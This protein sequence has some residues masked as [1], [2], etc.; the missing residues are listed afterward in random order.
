MNNQ[1][2]F[3]LIVLLFL[4][5]LSGYGQSVQL[6][7][8]LF[9]TGKEYDQAGK[10][11][12][13]E[14]YY[15]E[16]YNMYR[17]FQDTASWL[18]AGKEYASAMMWRSKNGQ[19]LELYKE[20][21][22]V[23]HP[24]N[25]VYNQ[26][27][28]YNSMGLASKRSGD[29]DQANRYYQKSLPLSKESGDS[30]LIGVVFSNIGGIQRAKGN[31]SKAMERFKQSLPYL[32]GITQNSYFATSL[33]NIGNI[34]E[35][36]SLYDQALDYFNR[37]L[38]IQTK[39]NNVSDLS[40]TYSSLGSVQQ[41]LGNYDQAMV[42][43]NK[44]LDFSRT[45]G[46]PSQTAQI[47]NDIG[48]LYKRLG[49]YDKALDYYRQSLAI[50]K[51]ASGPESIATTTNNIGQLMWE[52]GKKEEA[53]S[54]YRE[55]LDMRKKM[56]NPHEIYYSLNTMARMHL[57]N[58]Q[59]DE[60]E[61][62]VNQI[63]AIGD[64]TDSY[65]MLKRAST[66]FGRIDNAKGNTTS[67]LDHYRKAYAY[68]KYLSERE[69]LVPLSKL[70]QQYDRA[71]S[72]SAIVYGQKAIDIIEQ[73][74]SRASAVSDLKS[75]F[76]GQHTDFYTEVA[77]W[78]LTYSQDLSRAYKLVEQAKAR[79][80]S[81]ELA[82]ASQNIDQQLP[83]KVRVERREK[84]NRINQLY[85]QLEN[86]SD[87][88][89]RSKIE[90]KIRSAELDYAAYENNLHNEYPELK[91]L[92]SPEPISLQRAQTMADEQTAVLEYAVA[93]DQLIIF[94]ISQNTVRAEQ[95]SLSGDVPLD[96]QLTDLVADFKGAILSNAPR[97]QLRSQSA[98]LYNKLL[99]PFEKELSNFSN[100]II[101][102]DGAL[103][104]LPFEALSRGD[105]YLIEQF[106]IK[107]EPSLTS[108]DLLEDSESLDRQ[109][110]L[111]VAG[112]DF[113]EQ[114]L[115]QSTFRQGNLQSLP[116]T[117]M[118]VDSIAT[119]FQQSSI[120]K[121]DEVSEERFKKMLQQNQYRYI[122]MATHGII[123]ENN[124]SRSGLALS[125]KGEI[126]ASS[127]E[128]GML[129]SSE[130]FGLNINSDMVVLSACNTG[131]G[132]VVKGEG[133]LGMQRSFFYAGAS[134]VVVSLWNVYDRSTAS[135]MNEFYKALIN[136]E[137]QEGWTDSMLRWVGWDESIPF[138]QKATAMRQA[139]LQMIKHPLFNHPVYW[140]PF[141]VVGR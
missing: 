13:S 97:S 105:Q 115:Q 37:A 61:R 60:A 76:F 75:S 34:Y 3:L 136:S 139:K 17:E 116:S 48:L 41:S 4:I 119:Q 81:D 88:Q 89:Q 108:L 71:N 1:R 68:S 129:R 133:I 20:L 72:D 137:S 65:D 110:L 124:P 6:A 56:G 73:Q 90:D 64:S 10:N 55:A 134:T 77:S 27:D 80:L 43:Y 47:L 106:N 49:E 95:F 121:E 84:R 53:A 54:Y 127:R 14:F 135:F 30:L 131:L 122:H 85:T 26:G 9:Q 118:E 107:Y 123:D 87:K 70:A 83:E 51:E 93:N 63:Q 24:A 141:I 5:P 50:S 96:E 102:P 99:A 125:T 42:S 52:I 79:S 114:D 35:E 120:L 94:L 126:T 31:Y 62:Y 21:L 132:K 138:G 59:Y 12:E 25:D 29:L 32:R 100:L 57:G 111:A 104:Y 7:D 46:T 15:R 112:S 78:I 36:L 113:S 67:A 11:Q 74:R 23:D 58:Q 86:T 98:E 45:A 28:L 109:D 92:E 82:A 33:G 18:E 117:L 19:A 16:A 91:S 103:A 38:K 44:A 69:Q 8:S 101:V 128:D 140:A 66:Y 39:I 40:S 2:L 22:S 130:I